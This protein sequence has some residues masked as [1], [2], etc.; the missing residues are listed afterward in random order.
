[1]YVVILP[2]RNLSPISP[3]EFID[4]YTLPARL[5]P[6]FHHIPERFQTGAYPTQDTIFM[7]QSIFYHRI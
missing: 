7:I 2:E 3:P 4:K 5:M 1:M 6:K